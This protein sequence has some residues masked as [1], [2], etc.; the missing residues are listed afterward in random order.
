M[1]FSCEI[2]INRGIDEIIEK[3][4]NVDNMKEWMEGLQSFEHISGTSGQVGAKSKLVFLMGKRHIEMI[5]TITVR[6]LPHEFSGIYEAKGVYNIVQNYFSPIDENKT[7]YKTD[8]EFQFK[9]FMKIIGFLFPGAFKK[10]CMK[11]LVDFKNF[12]ERS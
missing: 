2:K 9:G 7:L 1:K 8:Q 6:N 4:D 11:Y 3:F 10:Q 5:E 12:V